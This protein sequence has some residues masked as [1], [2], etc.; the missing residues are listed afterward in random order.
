MSIAMNC[1]ENYV[2]K[3]LR[4]LCNNFPA[5]G[6]IVATPPACRPSPPPAPHPG[7]PPPA[8]HRSPSAATRRRQSA[9]LPLLGRPSPPFVRLTKSFGYN[10]GQRWCV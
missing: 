3:T 6:F 4:L 7:L 2:N 10:W 8:V 1:S 9:C 5:H